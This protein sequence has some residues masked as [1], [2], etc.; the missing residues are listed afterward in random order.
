MTRERCSFCNKEIK[1]RVYPNFT[2]YCPYCYKPVHSECEYGY[3]SVVPFYYSIGKLLIAKI[4][5]DDS[6]TYFLESKYIGKLILKEEYLDAIVESDKIVHN[7]ISKNKDE[8][9]K[10]LKKQ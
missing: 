7:L 9:I 3:G 5:C 8:I 1:F 6:Y 4:T 2:V 10:D